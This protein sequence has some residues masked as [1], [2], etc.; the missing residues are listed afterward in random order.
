MLFL[1]QD[2]LIKQLILPFPPKLKFYK[3]TQIQFFSTLSS[4]LNLCNKPN[5]LKQF[6][7]RCILHGHH[8]NLSLSSKLLECYANLGLHCLSLH[9][10]RS[11]SNPS[12]ELYNRVFQILA[13]SGESKQ[14]LQ[15]YDDMILNSIYPDEFTYPFVLRSC[16]LVLDVNYGKR[17]HGQ[18]V[19]LGFDMNEE[20]IAGLA[21]FYGDFEEFENAREVLDEMPVRGLDHWN[22]LL[23]ES[24]QNGNA[25]ESFRVFKQMMDVKICPNSISLIN[26]LRASTELN[27][28]KLGVLVH[29]LIVVN[30]LSRDLAV[31]TALLTMYS[32]LGNLKNASFVFEIMPEKDRVVWNLMISAYFRS[33]HPRKSLKLLVMMSNEGIRMDLYTALATIPA[34]GE[35][36]SLEWGKQIHALGIRNGL[37]YQVSV[38]NSLIDMYS[39]CDSVG[40]AVKVFDLI[41]EK[42]EVS[43]S[44]MIRGY[45]IHDRYVDALDLFTKMKFDGFSVD[46]AVAVSVLPACV[47]AGALEQVKY[48]HGCTIKYGLG[49]IPS[50]NTELLVSY[51]KC[52]CIEMARRL[53]DE[54]AIDNKDTIT[55]NSMI[56]A[57]SKHG[58]WERCFD[59]YEQMKKSYFRPDSVTFLGLLTACVNSGQVKE[60]WKIFTEMTGT[61]GVQPSQ[62]HYASMVDLLGKAGQISKATELINSMP[63]KADSRVWG[64]LLSACRMHSETAVAELAAEKLI[65]IEPTNAGNYILMSNIYAASGKWEK[66]A[67]MRSFLRDKGLKKTP[68]CSWLEVNGKVH[69]FRVAD[70]SHPRSHEIYS[71]LQYMELEI[72]ETIKASL[73]KSW[74]VEG[75]EH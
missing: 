69:E 25:R 54:E 70:K 21:E 9:V 1:K 24:L 38:Q 20:V 7:A 26:L 51:A 44:S 4:L 13:N 18:L 28:L 15:L 39:R 37:D 14:I 57:Y 47:N 35:L 49:S 58:E 66:V 3:T 33:G 46:S 68:G 40:A 2:C 19:K 55:W 65:A 52:G 22:F 42:T 63:I 56:S 27:S 48:I 30:G 43:W 29:S 36:K 60:G 71:I 6:H 5:L 67:K 17:V 32:K 61:Y 31:S 11:I 45:V 62:E 75:I 64:P 8:Q 73:P 72:E 41:T 10:F 34:V 23:V 74:I 16:K 12:L 50:V 59:L 53:F